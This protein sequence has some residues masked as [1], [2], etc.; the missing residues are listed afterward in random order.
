MRFQAYCY[1]FCCRLIAEF[2]LLDLSNPVNT[3][4][5]IAASSFIDHKLNSL[6]S[7]TICTYY[8]TFIFCIHQNCIQIKFL[9]TQI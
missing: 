6:H 2:F 5:A 3:V 9:V 4:I 7:L 8:L 1:H